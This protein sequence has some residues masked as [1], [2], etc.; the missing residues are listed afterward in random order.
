[1]LPTRAWEMLSGCLVFM[2]GNYFAARSVKTGSALEVF[3]WLD[4]LAALALFDKDPKWSVGL[5][6]LW[7]GQR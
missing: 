7:W 3:G 4:I 5:C 2:T 1:M 6:F